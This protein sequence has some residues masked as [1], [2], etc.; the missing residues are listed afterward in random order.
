MEDPPEKK[1]EVE[2]L[3]S[4][5]K[6]EKYVVDTSE[7][8]QDEGSVNELLLKEKTEAQKRAERAAKNLVTVENLEKF[9]NLK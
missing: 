8:P 9:S 2:E 7:R 3:P 1:S 5:I 6:R 4:L